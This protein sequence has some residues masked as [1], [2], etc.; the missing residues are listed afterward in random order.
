MMARMP[1][2]HVPGYQLKSKRVVEFGV[3][4]SQQCRVG[5]AHQ[6]PIAIERAQ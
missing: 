3:K 1:S 4:N 5:I 2:G 6:S